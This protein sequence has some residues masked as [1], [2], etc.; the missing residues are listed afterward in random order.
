MALFS[1]RVMGSRAATCMGRCSPTAW[2]A[3]PPPPGAQHPGTPTRIKRSALSTVAHAGTGSSHCLSSSGSDEGFLNKAQGTL[4]TGDK[5]AHRSPASVAPARNNSAA[6]VEVG[7]ASSSPAYH[8]PLA[9]TSL[10][11]AGPAC[12]PILFRPWVLSR[13]WGRFLCF[14]TSGLAGFQAVACAGLWQLSRDF[15]S[16]VEE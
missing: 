12:L 11:L 5:V 7:E 16:H 4:I 6:G 9:L 15:V 13:C 8:P 1:D 10:G 14:Q 2:K 3:P